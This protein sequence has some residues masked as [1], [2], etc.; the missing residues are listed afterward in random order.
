MLANV[1]R[2]G[3]IQRT[4]KNETLAVRVDTETLERVYKLAT[5][6]DVSTGEILRRALALLL[7]DGTPRAISQEPPR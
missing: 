2:R 3:P 4:R 7:G 5:E 1:M 6:E